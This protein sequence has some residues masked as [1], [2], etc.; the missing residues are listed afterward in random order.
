VF[1]TRGLTLSLYTDSGSHYL[2]TPEAGGPVG[3]YIRCR[4][5][6]KVRS[7]FFDMESD[8]MRLI[9]QEGRQVGN[10]HRQQRPSSPTRCFTRLAR[11]AG[12]T[13]V[14]GTALSMDKSRTSG[15]IVHCIIRTRQSAIDPWRRSGRTSADLIAWMVRQD[16]FGRTPQQVRRHLMAW[17][18]PK[19]RE[20]CIGMEINGYFAGKM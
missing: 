6:E 3:R 13:T 5:G 4:P 19:L 14:G 10:F 11:L 8:C 1:V 17:T 16:G 20:I 9:L 15:P 18:R 2:Q 12:T 7:C